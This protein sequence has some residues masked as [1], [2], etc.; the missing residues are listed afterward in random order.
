MS[1]ASWTRAKLTGESS[2]TTLVSTRVTPYVRNRDADFPCIV[3]S[4]PREELESTAAHADLKR[5]A[6]LQIQC[7]SRS[8]LEA[9]TIAEA[10]IDVLTPSTEASTCVSAVRILSLE[11][12]FADSYDGK[13]DLIYSTTITATLTGA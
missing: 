10:V 7:M 4:V 11:R 9:D 6:E 5:T 1:F 8:H 3:Y 2:V 12:E 13:P